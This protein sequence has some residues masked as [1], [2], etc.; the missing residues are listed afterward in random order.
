MEAYTLKN[1]R[2]PNKNASFHVL[3]YNSD[4]LFEL[5]KK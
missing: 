5:Q 2:S 3:F 1:Y 4:D